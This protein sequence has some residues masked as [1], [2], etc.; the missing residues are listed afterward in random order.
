MLALQSFYR[1]IRIIIFRIRGA[2]GTVHCSHGACNFVHKAFSLRSC[3]WREHPQIADIIAA[4]GERLCA[5]IKAHTALI[6][7]TPHDAVAIAFDGRIP[8]QNKLS[9]ILPLIANP[10][11]GDTAILYAA[12]E[13][14]LLISSRLS[15]RITHHNGKF[16]LSVHNAQV[17]FS[18]SGFYFCDSGS[19]FSFHLRYY[20]IRKNDLFI[21]F[22]VRLSV[23]FIVSLLNS[24]LLFIFC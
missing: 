11:T 7:G 2:T 9:I 16:M 4:D 6:D 17:A 23:C 12:F 10:F 13:G 24:L 3:R 8:F 21:I 14:F 22:R 1:A 20:S 18:D 19:N 5:N 15:V